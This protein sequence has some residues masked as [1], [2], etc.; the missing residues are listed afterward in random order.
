M[1]VT[2]ACH[3]ARVQNVAAGISKTAEVRTKLPV[4]L[5]HMRAQVQ[6]YEQ[7]PRYDQLADLEV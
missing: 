4:I 2:V 3:L 1:L 5:N 7:N 6:T